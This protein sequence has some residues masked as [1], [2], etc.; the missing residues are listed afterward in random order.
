M[1]LARRDQ[2]ARRSRCGYI[3]DDEQR[4]DRP[5]S[6]RALR[7]PGGAGASASLALLDDVTTSP[8]SRR[9]ASAPAAPGTRP[10]LI[11]GQAPT[12]PLGKKRL[13]DGGFAPGHESSNSRHSC[14]RG[15]PTLAWRSK[16][17]NSGAVHFMR[18]GACHARKMQRSDVSGPLQ[19]EI[20]N[21]ICTILDSTWNCCC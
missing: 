14:G 1:G 20:W 5:Q 11:L 17:A 12:V 19:I 18:L 16:A 8:A 15:S 3:V 6:P 13:Q 9:L 7:V 21:E 10:L 4:R 2:G